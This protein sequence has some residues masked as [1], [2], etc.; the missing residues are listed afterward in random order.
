M[1]SPP[2]KGEFDP[3]VNIPACVGFE[4]AGGRRQKALSEEV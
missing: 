2:G 4:E 3:P 1:A